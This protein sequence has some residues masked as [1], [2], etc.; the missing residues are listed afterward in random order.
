MMVRSLLEA[1]VDWTE[2]PHGA[3]TDLAVASL[4]SNVTFDRQEA[5]LYVARMALR[6]Q[7]HARLRMVTAALQE[8][9]L[10]SEP[11]VRHLELAWIR[12]LE[13]SQPGAVATVAE[14]LE[15]MGSVLK[16]TEAWA[17]AALLAAREGQH[18]DALERAIGL[19]ETHG[20]HPFL[21]PLPETRWLDPA[22]MDQ[23]AVAT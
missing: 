7:D 16:A 3:M 19:A 22:P 20:I 13:D 11:E 8:M 18:S 15:S 23:R 5:L 9:C 21:G 10:P 4:A 14:Q 2:E 17:D 6:L 1:W 12:G